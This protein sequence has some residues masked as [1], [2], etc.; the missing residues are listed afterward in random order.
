M[1]SSLSLH[2]QTPKDAFLHE[3]VA[4]IQLPTELGV[5]G[6]LPHHASMVF[7]L[8]SGVIHIFKVNQSLHHYFIN[9]GV[10]YV[11]KNT[12]FI[13]TEQSKSLKELDPMVL[14][15]VLEKY[16]QTLMGL[17]V[18]YER[19]FIEQRIKITQAMLRAV[20]ENL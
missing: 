3:E 20:K 8:A 17:D 2:I 16:H 7:S 11:V 6:I 4:H 5:V 12:C 19:R 1:K 18:D 14:S 10:A 15:E 9:P 13:M